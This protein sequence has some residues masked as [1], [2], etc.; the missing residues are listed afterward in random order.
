M[1][2]NEKEFGYFSVI[3]TTSDDLKMMQELYKINLS[4]LYSKYVKSLAK[5]MV[6]FPIVRFNHEEA[7]KTCK[8]MNTSKIMENFEGV[9]FL[10]TQILSIMNSLGIE[11]EMQ[12]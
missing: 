4:S 12:P 6:Q 8:N 3:E 5:S 10:I 11:G 1:K 7:D 9:N 2:E